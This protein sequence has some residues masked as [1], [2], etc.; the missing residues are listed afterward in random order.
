MHWECGFLTT[1]PPGKCL[2]WQ[3]LFRM[4]LYLYLCLYRSIICIGFAVLTKIV[5]YIH[6][7]SVAKSCPTLHDPLNCSILGLPVPHHLLEFAQVLVHW[8]GDAINHLILCCALL[9]LLSI[10]PSIR[11]FSNKSAVGIRWPKYWSF[12]FSISSSNDY[13]RLISFRIDW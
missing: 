6:C 12:S 9:L 8:I 3:F 10:F 7:C 11:V 13:S 5:K 4:Y 1:G 2:H